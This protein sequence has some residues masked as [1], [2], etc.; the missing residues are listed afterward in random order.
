[1]FIFVLFGFNAYAEGENTVSIGKFSEWGLE[2]WE[3]VEFNDETS[4]RLKDESDNPKLKVLHAISQASASGMFKKMKVNIQK[5]PFLNWR[6]KVNKPLASL[7]EETKQGDDYAARIYV[8][9]SDG[10][11]FWQTKALNYV[12]SSREDAPAS[13]PNAYAPDNTLMIPL[14][15]NSDG[16]GQWHIEKRNIQEDLKAW[17]GKSYDEVEAIAIMTDADD[18]GSNAEAE[19]GDIF[20]SER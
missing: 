18:S 19:Y 7:P 6:W 10:W 16:A 12:W 8:V 17:L 13:W 15:N 9:V 14:R 3:S 1:Y 11:F 4:Y 20:F 5:T 2:E